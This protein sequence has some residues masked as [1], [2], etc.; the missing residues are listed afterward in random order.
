MTTT[1][2]EKSEESN[3]GWEFA[4][5][6]EEP[7][8]LIVSYMHGATWLK[9]TRPVH[10]FMLMGILQE[11]L[12]YLTNSTEDYLSPQDCLLEAYLTVND[13]PSYMSQKETKFVQEF[14][15]EED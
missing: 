12:T 6:V 10:R 1:F 3:D 15:E 11:A 8:H 13:D 14:L 9:P 4:E 5:I 2:D 7:F